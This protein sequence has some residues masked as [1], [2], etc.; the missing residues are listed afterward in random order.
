MRPPS[1]YEKNLGLK[2]DEYTVRHEDKMGECDL[3]VYPLGQPISDFVTYHENLAS[4]E[5]YALEEA[6]VVV[7]NEEVCKVEDGTTVRGVLTLT[8]KLHY[9]GD[10]KDA[11]KIRADDKDSMFG[12]HFKAK[13]RTYVRHI[14]ING[15]NKK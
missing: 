15:R 1:Y 14:R 6:D 5:V 3:Q 8:A 9:T 2:E 4:H 7:V 13:K 10:L 11:K 12:E